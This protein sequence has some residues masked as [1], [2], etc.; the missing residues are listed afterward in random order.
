MREYTKLW[1][2]QSISRSWTIGDTISGAVGMLVGIVGHYSPEWTKEVSADLWLIPIYALA[3]TALCRFVIFAPYELWKAEREKVTKNEVILLSMG[4]ERP[5]RF[6]YTQFQFNIEGEHQGKLSMLRLG[7]VNMSD[8]LIQYELANVWI[9][10]EKTCYPAHIKEGKVYLHPYSQGY[11][12]VPLGELISIEK[13]PETVWVNFD[14]SYDT[15]PPIKKRTTG[16]KIRYE[17]TDNKPGATVR[18][19]WYEEQREH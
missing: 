13:F 11:F 18:G 2:K 12:D 17:L 8:R 9:E 19:P 1:F 14:Y 10:T 16:A 4:A 3:A 15:V 6:E 5:F 7:H